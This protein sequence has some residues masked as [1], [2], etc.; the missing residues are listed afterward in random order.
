MSV[1]GRSLNSP[2]RPSASLTYRSWNHSSQAPAH[3]RNICTRYLSSFQFGPILAND[4]AAFAVYYTLLC[5][6]VSQARIKHD[7]YIGESSSSTPS[8]PASDPLTIASRCQVNFAEHVP[9][10]LFL[11]A[12][13]E[14]NGGNR[15]VLTGSFAALIVARL[16]HV[17]LGL[18]G[19][20][21][22]GQGRLVGHLSTMGFIVGMGG[23][24][25]WLVKG[26]W[27][28]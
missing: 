12:V 24:A 7:K 23:Y 13:V 10:A 5:V 28:L 16:L 17:E 20:K 27:G 9:L 2:H 21:G 11:G 1:P 19:E 6:R 26:Y 3:H 4:L 14:M 18:R 22:I 15:K 8:D 25:A